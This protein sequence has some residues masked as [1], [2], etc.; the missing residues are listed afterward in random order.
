MKPKKINKSYFNTDSGAHL[1]FFLF[2]CVI[3]E[4]MSDLNQ[5]APEFQ[6]NLRLLVVSGLN[7]LGF[8]MS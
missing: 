1:S 5:R 2:W 8:Q 7:Q 6:E 3:V 4:M